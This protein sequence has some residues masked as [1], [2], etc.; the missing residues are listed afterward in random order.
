MASK[1]Y[2]QGMDALVQ[3]H[4]IGSVMLA[5]AVFLERQLTKT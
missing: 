2:C 1:R 3:K 5:P 4:R